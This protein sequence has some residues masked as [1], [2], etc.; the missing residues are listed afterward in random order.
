MATINRIVQ[1]EPHLVNMPPHC[2]LRLLGDAILLAISR[3]H[4][5]TDKLNIRLDLGH[6]SNFEFQYFAMPRPY[7]MALA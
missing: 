6:R 7:L 1:W 4:K 5:N 3:R 2:A